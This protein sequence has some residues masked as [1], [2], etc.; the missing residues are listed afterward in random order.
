MIGVLFV[1]GVHI[2]M[3]KNLGLNHFIDPLGLKRGP[4]S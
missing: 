2:D 3:Y 1:N 4:A